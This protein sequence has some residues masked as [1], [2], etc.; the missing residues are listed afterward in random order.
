LPDPQAN[1]TDPKALKALADLYLDIIKAGEQY[2]V[3]EWEVAAER[4]GGFEDEAEREHLDGF[5]GQVDTQK[6]YLDQLEGNVRVTPAVGM[7]LDPNVPKEAQCG[8]QLV[9]YAFRE[10]GLRRVC[11]RALL[12]CLVGSAGAAIDSY[13][14]RRTMPAIRWIHPKQVAWDAECAG[15][16]TR[17]GWV[18]FYE[19]ISPDVLWVQSEGK[20][21]LKKLRA[22][23]EKQPTTHTGDILRDVAGT[24][25]SAPLRKRCLLW[26][27]FGRNEYALYSDRPVDEWPLGGKGEAEFERFRT[28][29]EPRRYLELVDGYDEP[30]ADEP[31]WPREF[32]LDFDQWPVHWLTFN[33]DLQ[34]VAGFTDWR[35]VQ[36]ANDA[37]ENMARAISKNATASLA[38]KYLSHKGL[39][40]KP[41]DL[42]EFLRTGN[43]T[44]VLDGMVDDQ[45]KP[46]LTP[47]QVTEF[48]QDL[49]EAAQFLQD[50]SDGAARI[51]EILRGMQGKPG[52]TATE[53]DAR[54]EAAMAS[55]NQ[56]LRLYEEFEEGM[57]RRWLEMAYATMPRFSTI[58]VASLVKVGAAEPPIEGAPAEPAPEAAAPVEPP[59][60]AATA[61]LFTDQEQVPWSQ[62]AQILKTNPGSEIKRLGVDAIVGEAAAMFWPEGLPLDVIRRNIRVYVEVGSTTRQARF[63]KVTLL[64][65]LYQNLLLPLYQAVGRMDLAAQFVKIIVAKA[66]A[67]DAT[68]LVPKPEELL[69]AQQAQAAAQAAALAAG[70]PA[71]KPAGGPPA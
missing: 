32:A 35:H 23:A 59:P 12:S 31:D 16:I 9:Q 62:V 47:V 21:D 49:L 27:F 22:A 28:A 36:R 52:Q 42:E 4:Y 1:P 6:S 25:P 17:A 68:E 38:I 60:E 66:G 48:R 37:N 63:E 53:V 30:L 43:P 5:R 11:S 70:P 64:T 3:K 54:Q 46:L 24:G 34:H 14:E 13:D 18:A 58:A 71:A 29:H 41:E 67:D 33:E 57:A 56:R 50:K 40:A 55:T 7:A 69:A 45:G 20:L 19:F 2:P 8:E 26:R 10:L 61:L 44:K 39:A 65:D 15:D 51:D